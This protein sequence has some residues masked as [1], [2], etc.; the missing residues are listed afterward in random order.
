MVATPLY[1]GCVLPLS[2]YLTTVL[3]NVLCFSISLKC[4]SRYLS[5]CPG[6]DLEVEKCTSGIYGAISTNMWSFELRVIGTNA[7]RVDTHFFHLKMHT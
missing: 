5:S 1:V 6:S 7:H 3:I 4:L 2:K